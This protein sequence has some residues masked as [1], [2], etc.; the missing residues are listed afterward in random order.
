MWGGGGTLMREGPNKQKKKKLVGEGPKTKLAAESQF[1]TRSK[2][3]CVHTALTEVSSN[4]PSACVD[5][6][7]GKF[8]G[9]S[10]HRPI[11]LCH[12]YP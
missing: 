5:Q 10:S 7:C 4:S 6:L 12:F 1:L 11:V 9:T 8:V 3:L 2:K